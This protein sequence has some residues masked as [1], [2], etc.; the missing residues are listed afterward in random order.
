M[1]AF[2]WLWNFSIVTFATSAALRSQL[3]ISVACSQFSHLREVPSKLWFTDVNDLRE[4]DYFFQDKRYV[5]ETWRRSQTCFGD[6]V[7]LLSRNLCVWRPKLSCS[8]DCSIKS[9]EEEID[10]KRADFFLK[11]WLR[12]FFS[13]PA[14]PWGTEM[15][16]PLMLTWLDLMLSFK[17]QLT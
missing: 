17:S 9:K 16:M 14:S 8:F 3:H 5:S 13:S 15:H 4:S 12:F 1:H 10:L 6:A 11:Y 7:Y 2:L